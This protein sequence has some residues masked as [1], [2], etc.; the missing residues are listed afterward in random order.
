MLLLVETN[1]F[2]LAVLLPDG[3]LLDPLLLVELMI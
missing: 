2:S 1:R 3:M